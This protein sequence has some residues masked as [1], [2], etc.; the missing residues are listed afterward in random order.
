MTDKQFTYYAKAWDCILHQAISLEQNACD[1]FFE[2]GFQIDSYNMR[3]IKEFRQHIEQ[4]IN[5]AFEAYNLHK[6]VDVEPNI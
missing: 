5:V 4:A 1:D 3:A 2:A 6:D